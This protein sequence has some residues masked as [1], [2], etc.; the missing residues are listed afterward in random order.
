MPGSAENPNYLP[1]LISK[2]KLALARALPWTADGMPCRP[3]GPVAGCPFQTTQ[4]DRPDSLEWMLQGRRPATSQR[5][6][7]APRH[8]RMPC[9]T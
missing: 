7:T 3:S 2:E 8:A 1:F 6:Y 4:A 5:R 9:H